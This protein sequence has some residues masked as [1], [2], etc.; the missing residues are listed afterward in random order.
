MGPTIVCLCGSTRFKDDYIAAN[1][2]ETLAGKIV[3]SVGM[4]G[5]DEGIDMDGPVKK[6]LDELH[7]RKIDLAN[8]ILVIDPVGI[9][10]TQCG[11]PGR[12]FTEL[13]Q[14]TDCCRSKNWVVRSYIGESTRKEIFY[15]TKLG[16]KVRFYSTERKHE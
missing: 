13:S 6:M 9:V 2:R 15:A 4:F 5:H 16:K 11:K 10:C 14:E 1:R 3:L 8:E 7:L 12:L